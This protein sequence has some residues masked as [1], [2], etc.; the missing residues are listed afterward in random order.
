MACMVWP[1]AGI[2]KQGKINAMRQQSCNSTVLP[3]NFYAP[4]SHL[5]AK[6]WITFKHANNRTIRL[7]NFFRPTMTANGTVSPFRNISPLISI[8]W[9]RP[10]FS[11][12]PLPSPLVEIPQP[13]IQVLAIISCFSFIGLSHQK[14]N[15][16]I[17]CLLPPSLR[18]LLLDRHP[19]TGSFWPYKYLGRV[20][21]QIYWLLEGPKG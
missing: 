17:T 3:L 13:R 15:W 7:I 2:P 1:I 18:C 10:Q 12:R 4:E 5:P 11:D 14:C 19:K 21:P 6:K 8:T 20:Q 9:L 16:S